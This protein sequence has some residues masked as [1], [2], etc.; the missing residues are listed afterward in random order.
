VCQ[1]SAAALP[2]L[3]GQVDAG[4]GEHGIHAGRVATG[5]ALWAIVVSVLALGVLALA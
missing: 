3:S 2:P 5:V 1:K 4:E